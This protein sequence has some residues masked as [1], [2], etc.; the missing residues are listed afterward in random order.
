MI[1]TERGL[2]SSPGVLPHLL[3]RDAYLH[4]AGNQTNWP[5]SIRIWCL[6]GRGRNFQLAWLHFSSTREVP[7]IAWR[8]LEL[9]PSRWCP[10]PVLDIQMRHTWST[11]PINPAALPFLQA[12]QKAALPTA[13]SIEIPEFITMAAAQASSPSTLRPLQKPERKEPHP[14]HANNWST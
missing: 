9:L 13:S 2:L 14:L 12:R 4:T 3:A 8:W 10:N 1:P 11:H 7:G 5:S 6:A